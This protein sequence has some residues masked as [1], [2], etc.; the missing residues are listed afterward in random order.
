[1]SIAVA[2]PNCSAKKTVFGK[3]FY[4]NET[5]ATALEFALI[6]TPFFFLLFAII[7]ITMVFFVSI[8]MEHATMEVARTIR[9]GEAQKA[10]GSAGKFLDAVCAEMNALVPCAGNVYI[11]VRTYAD[12][13]D[14]TM[15]TPIDDDELD[16][17][18]FKYDAGKAGDIVV[19]RVFYVWQLNTPMLGTVFS[20]LS[21]DRRLIAATTAF[22]NEPFGDI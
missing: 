15:S 2:P 10:S 3:R 4:R 1:M 12:F 22:R 21:G 6:A 9:T 11:D 20:N 17:G 7:E 16:N 14:V 8:S 19:V 13:G 5:G 18:N